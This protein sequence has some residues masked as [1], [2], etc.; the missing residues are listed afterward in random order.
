[1]ELQSM[2]LRLPHFHAADRRAPYEHFCVNADLSYVGL[3]GSPVGT[4][5]AA[6]GTCRDPFK[7]PS[8][9]RRL[10]CLTYTKAASEAREHPT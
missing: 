1:V 9:L 4:E 3:R 6:G 5:T 7:G 8:F 2:S 10:Y